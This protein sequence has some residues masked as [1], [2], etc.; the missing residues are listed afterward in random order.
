LTYGAANCGRRWFQKERARSFRQAA[1]EFQKVIDHPG[2]VGRFVTGSLVRL[3]LGRAQA[4]DGD[5]AATRKSYQE[6][7]LLWQ[8]ADPDIPIYTQAK[9]EYARLN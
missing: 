9:A 2:I 5:Q 1:A 7:L 8:D 4:M 6:F 3:Q